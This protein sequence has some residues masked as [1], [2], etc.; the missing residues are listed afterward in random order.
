MRVPLFVRLSLRGAVLVAA[1]VALVAG[2][3]HS[4]AVGVWRRLYR[5]HATSDDVR[6]VLGD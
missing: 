5:T 4:I 2:L 3:G 1:L 6:L